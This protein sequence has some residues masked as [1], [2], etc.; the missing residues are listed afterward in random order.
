MTFEDAPCLSLWA[1]LYYLCY[2]LTLFTYSIDILRFPLQPEMR[3]FVH[4]QKGFQCWLLVGFISRMAL[5]QFGQVGVVCFF[6]AIVTRVFFGINLVAFNNRKVESVRFSN[7]T[8]RGFHL[9]TFFVTAITSASRGP[10]SSHSSLGP[11]QLLEQSRQVTITF[12]S[13]FFRA[14]LSLLLPQEGHEIS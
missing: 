6:V 11:I 5:P 10:V 8:Q 9:P 7:I 2:L 13:S 4:P 14:V 12:W 3:Y 1:L